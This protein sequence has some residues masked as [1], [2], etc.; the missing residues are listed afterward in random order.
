MG[1]TIDFSHFPS[2]LETIE[3]QKLEGVLGCSYG[4]QHLVQFFF[5][6]GV[7]IYL[8]SEV[9]G[10]HPEEVLHTVLGWESFVMEW[11][12]LQVRISQPNLT[13]D[14]VI[15]LK[16]VLTILISNGKFLNPKTTILPVDFF[17]TVVPRHAHSIEIDQPAPADNFEVAPVQ[18]NIAVPAQTLINLR[19][20]ET[21][22]L[23]S[24]TP[25]KVGEVSPVTALLKESKVAGE[26]VPPVRPHLLIESN[27][28][29]P[30]G[31]RQD[32]LEE[33]LQK[34]S[35]K[36]QLT[37]LARAHFTGY[38]YYHSSQENYNSGYG[39]VL[40]LD[41]VAS[42]VVYHSGGNNPRL[43]GVEAY[44]AIATQNFN[45]KINKVDGRVLKAYR[46]MIN[47]EK[48]QTDIKLTKA[49]FASAVTAF[50]QTNRDGLIL[51]Y[52]DKLKLHYFF[53]FEAGNQ[54]GVFG[55][56]FKS[57]QLQPLTAP[58]ALPAEDANALMSVMLAGKLTKLGGETGAKTKEQIAAVVDWGSAF[59]NYTQSQSTN[60]RRQPVIADLDE[61][62]DNP[63]DF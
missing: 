53:F 61:D 38:I 9:Q 1:R 6:K 19:L 15:A 29:L 33:L 56:D 24:I 49:T 59:A 58:I 5:R 36:E 3:T 52:V 63:Y 10:Q 2:V 62:E 31:V 43:T 60:P 21:D 23:S 55:S 18:L 37:A 28:L 8:C 13:E 44:K 50:K 57:G 26:K 17:P 12:P 4:D 41:G 46:A 32:Q 39:L 48:S 25:P 14:I 34:V 42:D 51:V 45:S 16:D 27:L 20:L 22:D 7:L 35:L 11:L 47:S 40:M 54:V 30:P